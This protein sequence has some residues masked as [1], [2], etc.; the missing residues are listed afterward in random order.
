MANNA[1]WNG[2][3]AIFH[4]ARALPQAERRAFVEKACQGDKD[5][6]DNVWRMLEAHDEP[7]FLEEPPITGPLP[8]HNGHGDLSGRRIGHYALKRKIAV[9]GMGVVY[10]AVQQNPHRSV[11]LKL[12]RSGLASRSALRRFEFESQLLAR[13][14]HPGIA[15]VYEAGTHDDGTGAVPFFAMEYIVGARTI[16]DYAAYK[17][18]GTR[19]RLDLFVQVCDAVHHAHQKGIIH[20]DLKPSNILVDSS[21]QPKVI[22]FGVARATDSD[23]AITTLQTN[24]GQLIGT[25]QYMSPEQCHGD[26]NDLDTRSDVYALGA[27]GYELLCGKPPFNL[28][29]MPIPN[30]IK[31]IQSQTPPRPSQIDHTL[32]G[33]LETIVLKALDK[34]RDRRYESAADLGQ[35]I[36]RYLNDEPIEARPPSLT[37]QLRMLARRNRGAF[38]GATAVLAFLVAGIAIAWMGRASAMRAQEETKQSEKE[39]TL[40]MQLLVGEL[41]GAKQSQKAI[42]EIVDKAELRP[43]TSSRLRLALATAK[44]GRRDREG[45]AQEARRALA[46]LDGSGAHEPELEILIGDALLEALSQSGR[47][48]EAWEVGSSRI[49]PRLDAANFSEAEKVFLKVRVAMVMPDTMNEEAIRRM[50]EAVRYYANR[51]SL[52]I[53]ERDQYACTLN[54]LASR[55]ADVKRFDD[56]FGTLRSAMTV[57]Q[58]LLPESHAW[59]SGSRQNLGTLMVRRAREEKRPELL[60]EAESLL[61]EAVRLKMEGGDADDIETLATQHNLARALARQG[62]V[63]EAEELWRYVLERTEA[64]GQ[65]TGHRYAM[66]CHG[67]GELLLEKGQIDEAESLAVR[68][69]TIMRSLPDPSEYRDRAEELFDKVDKAKKETAPSTK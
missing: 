33:D 36:G 1:G 27:V 49:L 57:A 43:T 5:L 19:D 48:S 66:F 35:D 24:V 14:R 68:A 56:A 3:W 47:T 53:R 61:R 41:T 21:G 59:A 64:T 34:D 29:S 54:R 22:D 16:T 30:A 65:Q 55:F 32:R 12:M 38:L 63:E 13:L 8:A 58:P 18:M 11:A 67:L 10:E 4:D 28:V 51:E 20:R 44:L 39:Q 62:K 42:D 50:Q 7:G 2:M 23:M 60:P 45:G 40:F 25:L 31:L 37:Y 9:G 52:T 69:V 26:P 17:T 46:I 15:Q 6:L